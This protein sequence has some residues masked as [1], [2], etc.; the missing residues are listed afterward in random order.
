MKTFNIA[1][2]CKKCGNDTFRIVQTKVK[3]DDEKSLVM[4]QTM[5]HQGFGWQMNWFKYHCERCGS[6]SNKMDIS[7]NVKRQRAKKLL[8]R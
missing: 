2:K 4:H 6:K 3:S 1:M 7:E 8:P 5:C